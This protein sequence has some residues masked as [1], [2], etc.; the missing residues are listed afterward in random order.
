MRVVNFNLNERD[1][2]LNKKSM[3]IWFNDNTFKDGVGRSIPIKLTKTNIKDIN[4]HK[5]FI[6]VN[7]NQIEKTGGAIPLLALIP[8][9][10]GMFGGLAGGASSI[11]TAVHAKNKMDKE[12]EE[13]K[14][15]NKKIEGG[16]F[17]LKKGGGYVLKKKL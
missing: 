2:D 16:G 5:R 9:L 7:P 4:E 11:A 10:A 14:R 15:H 6:T 13:Q 12:I 1:I 3:R 8:A 17:V